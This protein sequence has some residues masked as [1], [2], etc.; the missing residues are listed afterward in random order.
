VSDTAHERTV[1]RHADALAALR[2]LFAVASEATA[3]GRVRKLNG[4][5]VNVERACAL[6]DVIGKAA[7]ECEETLTE[8]VDSYNAECRYTDKLEEHADELREMLARAMEDRTAMLR[9]LGLTD[10]QWSSQGGAC[11][12]DFEAPAAPTEE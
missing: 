6:L 12:T 1:K 9:R 11:E 8:Y 3:G 5:L 2:K 7:A 10:A 4:A